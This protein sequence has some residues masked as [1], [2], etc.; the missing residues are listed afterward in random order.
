MEISKEFMLR[1]VAGNF[2]VVPFGEKSISFNA[3]ITLNETGAF[4]WKHLEEEKTEGELLNLMIE[5]YDIDCETAQTDITKF[6]ATLKTAS[7][8]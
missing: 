6:L 5:E 8:I 4:L 3:M 7:I 2:I 1:E